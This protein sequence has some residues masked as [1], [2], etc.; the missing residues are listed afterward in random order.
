MAGRLDP[1]REKIL[2]EAIANLL[3]PGM[4]RGQRLLRDLVLNRRAGLALDHRGSRLH[5]PVQN[6]IGDFQAHGIT[7]SKF[8]VDSEVE[9]CRS[10]FV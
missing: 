2:G 7:T 3:E 8:A 1:A 4:N 6:N 9:G 10:G 5:Y